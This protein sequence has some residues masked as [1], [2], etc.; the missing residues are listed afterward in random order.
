M[1]V[2]H[3]P[4]LY[5]ET[6]VFGSH[7]RT[8]SGPCRLMGSIGCTGCTKSGT[9]PRRSGFEMAKVEVEAKARAEGGSDTRC[10]IRAGS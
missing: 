7:T 9:R 8:G 6:S 10:R 5:I 4:L 2:K 3:Q 1:D